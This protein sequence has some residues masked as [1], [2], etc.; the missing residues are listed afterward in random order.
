[1]YN[2][3]TAIIEMVKNPVLNIKEYTNTHNRAN[4]MGE[5]LEEYIKNLF[6]RV[7]SNTTESERMIKISKCF[8]YTGNQNN[9]PDAMI[10]GGDALEVKK[11]E[12]I[13]SSLAL[14][15]SYP[16]AK[17]FS[18]SS[19]ISNA[20]RTAEEWKEKD[21]IYAVGVITNSHLSA[22]SFVY[23]MDYAASASVYEN[24][25]NAVCEGINSI[26]NLEFSETKELGRINRVDPLG[27]TYM[28]IRGMW[29]IENPFK[30]FS[31]IYQPDSQ[32]R[33]NFMAII[34]KQKYESFGNTKELEELSKSVNE[35]NVSDVLI[36]NPDNPA[37]LRKAK[38]ITFFVGPEEKTT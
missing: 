7:D 27:I 29:G 36:K 9:P 13:G 18:S 8:S 38:L 24:T 37:Q 21:L 14:N 35:L 3:I 11:I 30:V 22:L 17:L 32:N 15:S 33:F 34:N 26:S 6:A 20:C 25:K 5:S 10:R 28:R 23:G 12:K 4:S 16:K 31:Y 1:M 2:I 19:M